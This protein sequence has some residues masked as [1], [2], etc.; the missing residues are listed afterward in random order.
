MKKLLCRCIKL[1]IIIAILIL[2][3][4]QLYITFKD[5]N[6]Q[7]IEVISNEESTILENEIISKIEKANEIMCELDKKKSQICLKT[8]KDIFLPFNSFLKEKFDVSS[9]SINP[10]STLLLR[11]AKSEHI[12]IFY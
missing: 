5:Q 7:R 11:V 4:L 8:E 3:L 1:K 12:K 2:M 6:V 10:F 9:F